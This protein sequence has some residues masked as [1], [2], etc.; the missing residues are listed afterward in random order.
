MVRIESRKWTAVQSAHLLVL[1][2]EGCSAS[3]IAIKLKR[4]IIVIRAKARNLGKSFPQV[5]SHS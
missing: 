1:I 2:D 5:T 4:S 3:S